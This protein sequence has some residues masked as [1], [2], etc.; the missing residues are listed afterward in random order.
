MVEVQFTW[1]EG[2]DQTLGAPCYETDGAAGA[3]IRANLTPDLRA[4]GMIL[5]PI[6]IREALPL[7]FALSPDPGFRNS[8]I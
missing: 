6:P 1:S 8:T 3:D 2:A 5:R 4:S 7:S